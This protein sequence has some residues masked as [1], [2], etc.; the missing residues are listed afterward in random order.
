MTTLVRTN[1]SLLLFV[2]TSRTLSA[3]IV[4]VLN[5]NYFLLFVFD[6]WIILGLCTFVC[7]FQFFLCCL[8]NVNKLVFYLNLVRIYYFSFPSV[9]SLSERECFRYF[10]LVLCNFT[11]R[12]TLSIKWYQYIPWN[13]PCFSWYFCFYCL[14]IKKT[15]NEGFSFSRI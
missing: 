11:W 5:C 10:F 8:P 14:C 12:S 9:Y 2:W 15:L 4:L 1:F 13:R 3:A 6:V 7:L